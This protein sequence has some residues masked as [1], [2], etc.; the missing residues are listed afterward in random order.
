M[1]LFLSF[2]LILFSF[3]LNAQKIKY[4]KVKIYATDEALYQLGNLGVAIDHG[5]RKKNTFFISDF[6][7]NEIQIMKEHG[8]QIEVL[9]DDVQEYYKEQ[10]RAQPTKNAN[11]TGGSNQGGIP[12][13]ANFDTDPN[14]YAGMYKYQEMLNE[15]DDMAAQYPNLIT[16][17]SPISNF[18]THEGRP[19]YYVKISDNPNTDDTSEPN[20]LYTSIH[21]AR[22]P[23][24][25]S[26]TIFYMWYLL[27][28]YSTNEEVKY[29]VDNMEMYFVPCI[30][31]DGYIHNEA[32]DPSGFGMHRKNKRNVG[33]S[34][35]GVDLN[36]N[37]S[38]QWGTTGVSADPNSDVYPG[39]GPF[40]EP[41][42]QAIKWMVENIG[43]VT[44]F[45]AHT[46]GKLLLFPIG[47]TSSEFA[48]HHNYFNAYSSHMASFNG[49]QNMK[50][51]GLYP[52]SGDSDDYMYKVDI[53]T[54][55]KDTIFSMTPEVG[56]AFWP[57]AA[58]VIPTCQEMVGP[59]M[60]LAHIT[61][62]YLVVKDTDPTTI[63]TTTG[64]FNFSVERLGLQ[65]ASVIVSI[66][67]LL[68]IQSVGSGIT[69]NLNLMETTTGAISY[70]LSPSIQTGDQVKYILKTEYPLWT[71]RDTI[72]KTFGTPTLQFTDDAST[73]TNWT[74]SWG[75]A[76]SQY[77]S[78]ST[79]FADSPFSNYTNN[80]SK[81]YE[82]NQSIDLTNASSAMVKFYAK[83]NI[84]A[85]YDYCQFQVS[86]DGGATWI[87]QC[88]LYT[89]D[90]TSANGSVQPDGKPVYEGAQN[91]WVLEEISLSDYLGQMIKVR[92]IM[93][94]DGGVTEDG[95]YFDDFQILYTE[96]ST[97]SID[98]NELQA[99]QVFP[100]PARE[101]AIIA[102]P[103]YIDK[104]KVQIFDQQGKKMR[105]I[106]IGMKSNQIKVKTSD[107]SRG[108]YTVRAV[109][110]G[111]GYSPVKLVVIH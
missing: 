20:V 6:S 72:V 26:Q 65:A 37:Y 54:G 98:E 71:K 34:N 73:G 50:S 90:G 84:E 46:H 87:G 4:S 110:D 100:N 22:E 74:G 94:S 1:K 16:I 88:G 85:D 53:G 47:A 19:I 11:C 43:F 13:P 41:E 75:I 111:K 32:N 33:T 12:V 27:E 91:S 44:A 83:W 25:M 57:P 89:V 106:E 95:F 64:N 104:G 63:A 97:S 99:L 31:P 9:I 56:S 68:N 96:N 60:V 55:M 103:E 109:L 42:T 49:Y 8:Y 28:N 61:R 36:R 59:N 14:S 10:L 108:V 2:T 23:L 66:E 102:L 93:E 45:N 105:E 69:Y 70:T 21:H 78:P 92:F 79:S 38:Y 67:P 5:I 77:Y 35:P 48:D 101:Y 76:T 58:E 29:L 107:L 40:S 62:P 17:K 24:S 15:L 18:L 51:S 52:A 86:T 82:L 3:S 81:T 80:S 7:E 30:N 39:T